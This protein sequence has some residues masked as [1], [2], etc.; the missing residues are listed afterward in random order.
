M[1]ALDFSSPK[2]LG[3]AMT[4]LLEPKQSE[5][6]YDGACGKLG[7]LLAAKEYIDRHHTQ[8]NKP[9]DNIYGNEIHPDIYC[10][11]IEI[12]KD[13]DIN[14]SNLLNKNTIKKDS[15]STQKYDVIIS[16]LPCG[17]KTERGIGE[18]GIETNDSAN[19][20][21]QHYIDSLVDGGR[22]AIVVTNSLLFSQSNAFIKLRK[23]LI[24]QC[25]LH[26]I[27]GLPARTFSY[28]A[29]KCSVLFFVKGMAT[30]EIKYYAKEL[31]KDYSRFIDF[32]L[33]NIEN[34]RSFIYSIDNIN[35]ETFYLPDAEHGVIEKEIREKTK[36]FETFD[37]YDI[38]NVCL[39]I[40]LTKE[41]FQEKE[42]AIYL[43]KLGKSSCVTDIK[44]TILKHQNYFQLVFDEKKILNEYI[45]Y[46]LKSTLGQIILERCYTGS[47]ISNITKGSLKS[48][49]KIYAPDIEK[50]KLIAKTFETL[51]EVK[52][53]MDG[54]AIQFSSAP[55]TAKDL[56][57][58]LLQTKDVF[59]KLSMEE[60]ILRLIESGENLKVEFKETLSKN[61]HTSQK[62]KKLQMSV[63]KNIVG[64]LNR[65]GGKLLIGVSDKGEVK[66]IE[67]DF[68]TNED[69]YKL[70]LS[71]LINDNIGTK[72]SKYINHDIYTVRSKKICLIQCSKSLDP[73]YLNGDFYIRT[74]PECRKLSSQEAYNY[75][76]SHFKE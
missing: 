29:I 5:K 66:G 27:L 13:H 30:K 11:A 58:K 68:Y 3:A 7:F 74:N 56:L 51:S 16:N 62:D 18:L 76:Q 20:F 63:L 54:M 67:S 57:D 44:Q 1:K 40:N 26:T 52:S 14:T 17:L 64:F 60:R 6:I 47:T 35:R 39:E 10:E 59:N 31:D 72:E 43:P 33:N 12:A 24:E 46:Y 65:D 4:T 69:K 2:A 37:C 28:A 41:V 38:D 23:S 55:N 21:L 48:T 61:I 22:A 53:L 25:D 71:N 15:K 70:L 32:A 42:N 36:N 73:A 49:L 75:I 45:K 50:Q 19:K 34:E 9:F 8:S